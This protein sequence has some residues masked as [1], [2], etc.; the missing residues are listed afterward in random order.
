MQIGRTENA[1]AALGV[2]GQY[3]NCIDYTGNVSSFD[4]SFSLSKNPFIAGS[5]EY[6]RWIGQ[7]QYR[8]TLEGHLI[9]LDRHV[10]VRKSNEKSR[11]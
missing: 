10:N 8:L 7:R 9:E 4:R 1:L 6:I 3:Y 5:F 11:K 2:A